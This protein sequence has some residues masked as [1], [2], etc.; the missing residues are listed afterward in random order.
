M[1]SNFA[2]L[3]DD[4]SNVLLESSLDMPYGSWSCSD[5]AAR[6][7]APAFP[8]FTTVDLLGEDI[9]NIN[10]YLFCGS[11]P[12]NYTDPTG[13]FETE[14]IKPGKSY[15]AIFVLPRA[16]AKG[17]RNSE[18]K[19]VANK[20]LNDSYNLIS[21]HKHPL[22]LVDDIKDFARAI[23]TLGE[24]NNSTD[25]YILTS[26]GNPGSFN[27]GDD[28]V[29]LFTDFTLLKD[30][31]SGL[32]IIIN[33]C[34][35]ANGNKGETFLKYFAETLDC[36]VFASPHVLDPKTPYKYGHYDFSYHS[37]F[38]NT[39]DTRFKLGLPC[40]VV[41]DVSNLSVSMSHGICGEVY[42]YGGK[43]LTMSNLCSFINSLLSSSNSIN[44]TIKF[45]KADDP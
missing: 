43:F 10:P 45:K 29:N 23:K 34:E 17:Y 8:R 20:Q 25:I 1:T 16:M 12:I 35:V 33:A 42:M 13:L 22:I 31:L 6:T 41:L 7:L 3:R 2:S 19:I 15:K 21:D 39:F 9:G 28:K 40:G 5:F 27:I 4:A 37:K 14:N 44:L 11:D 26:H 36:W 18:G 32:A 24:Q 38:S 30:K